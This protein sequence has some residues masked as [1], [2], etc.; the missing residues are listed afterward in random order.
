MGKSAVASTCNL[1][2]RRQSSAVR[3]QDA[4]PRARRVFCSVLLQ[5]LH[6][7]G[8]EAIFHRCLPRPQRLLHLRLYGEQDPE[9]GRCERFPQTLSSRQDDPRDMFSTSYFV[10]S[11]H[12]VSP[13]IF[14]HLWIRAAPPIGI[15]RTAGRGT[16]EESSRA[17]GELL[18][19]LSNHLGNLDRD[20]Q[21]S[22][23]WSLKDECKR[24]M[25]EERGKMKSL[26]HHGTSQIRQ[27]WLSYLITPKY[28]CMSAVVACLL[29]T[30]RFCLCCG[31]LCYW[32]KSSR[33]F[34]SSLAVQEVECGA[35]QF[36]RDDSQMKKLQEEATV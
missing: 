8:Q 13:P 2:L 12:P 19:R 7:P 3:C 23:Q 16:S 30:G 14:S 11:Y 29:E 17:D 9:R 28:H 32:K 33:T 5:L 10:F 36:Q 31:P 34:D 4:D 18:Q 21:L 27:N 1:P 26:L 6:S 25:N 15:P 24:R 22:L 35:V 20:T